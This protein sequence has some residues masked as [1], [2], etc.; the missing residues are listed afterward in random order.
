MKIEC[1]LPDSFRQTAD[2][3]SAFILANPEFLSEMITVSFSDDKL[4]GMRASRVVLLTYYQNP[5]LVKKFIPQILD[6][7]CLTRNNSTIRNLLHLFLDNIE[8]LDESK[9]GKLVDFCF[10]LLESPSAE[11]AQRALAMQ[12]LFNASNIITDFKDEL[13]AIIEF[14]YEEGS[15]GFKSTAKS[16]LKKLDK[17]TQQK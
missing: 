1:L 14:H 6:E 5:N 15:P 9:F 2:L 10:K 13:K 12:I 7:L 17:E 8:V 11:I 3:A 16:I 4:M